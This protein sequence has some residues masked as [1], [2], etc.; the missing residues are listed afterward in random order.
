MKAIF[1]SILK[2]I[3]AFAFTPLPIHILSKLTKYL[4]RHI[5]FL[6]ALN[7]VKAK[8]KTKQ[9]ISPPSQKGLCNRAVDFGRSY[10][11]EIK[12]YFSKVVFNCK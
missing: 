7:I 12:M 3:I 9:P 11:I 8:N 2:L 1:I 6:Y 5:F 4:T 10:Y